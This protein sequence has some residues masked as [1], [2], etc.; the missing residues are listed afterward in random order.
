MTKTKRI[1]SFVLAIVLIIPCV[2]LMT[3]CGKDNRPVTIQI[4]KTYR[5]LFPE[6]P[7]AESQTSEW[8]TLECLASDFLAIEA[9]KQYDF[10]FTKKETATPN[11]GF[12]I[13]ACKRNNMS[14]FDWGH[15]S[16]AKLDGQDVSSMIS[17]F[18]QGTIYFSS[19]EY[20][21]SNGEHTIS[22][23]FNA[24]GEEISVRAGY[25]LNS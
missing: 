8:K 3:A 16:S 24:V 25:Y 22:L 5:D 17:N 23:I 11:A 10:V 14:L 19:V 15:I 4:N 13:N 7:W 20:P 9:N 18:F 2:F 12:L 21:I 1:L 6:S